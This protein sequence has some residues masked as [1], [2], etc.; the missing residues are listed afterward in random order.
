MGV[1]RVNES[2]YHPPRGIITPIKTLISS[3]FHFEARCARTLI[4][5]SQ[6]LMLSSVPTILF[7]APARSLHLYAMTLSLASMSPSSSA[8]GALKLIYRYSRVGEY[9]RVLSPRRYGRARY[10]RRCQPRSATVNYVLQ[11]PLRAP[12]FI[13][14]RFPGRVTIRVVLPACSHA[15]AANRAV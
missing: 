14:R 12:S 10:L 13:H 7:T 2:R 3:K 15:A 5:L 9:Y 6:R 1:C 11:S 8:N 4:S